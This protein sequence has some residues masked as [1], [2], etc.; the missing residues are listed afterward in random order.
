MALMGSC[1]IPSYIHS[2]QLA[3]PV[4]VPLAKLLV[5][6]P[7]SWHYV[8]GLRHLYWDQ[9]T[10]GLELSDLKQSTPIVMGVA[11]ALSLILA[12]YTIG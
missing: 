5:A 6:F 11:G 12:F 7:L 2:F 10:K 3:A 1:D 9:T 4:L 8:V